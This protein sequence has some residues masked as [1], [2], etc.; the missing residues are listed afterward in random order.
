MVKM[1]AAVCR[2]PGMTHAEYIAYVHRVHGG[3]AQANPL[4]IQRYVQNHVFDAAFGALTDATHSQVVARDSIT[5]LFWED[6]SAMAQTF[7][8]PYTRDTV[9]PDARHFADTRT[10]LSLIAEEQPLVVEAPAHAGAKVMHF[11]RRAP[12]LSQAEFLSRWTSAHVRVMKDDPV[13]AASVRRAVQS[14]QLSEGEQLLKYFGNQEVLPYEGVGSLWYDDESCVGLFRRYE[15][16]LLRI[17]AQADTEF[18]VPQAS[19][20]VCAREVQII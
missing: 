15:A 1:M 9:G 20:F 8:H 6:F 3:L 5:E 7:S 18:Y 17:N 14:R 10:T 11:L 16:G 19:F 13:V 2:R 4:T 12:G